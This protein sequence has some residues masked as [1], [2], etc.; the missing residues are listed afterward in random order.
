MT[1]S[2]A[3]FRARLGFPWC[4]AIFV[5]GSVLT[6]LP[7]FF[8]SHYY[9]ILGAG[10]EQADNP[11]IHWWHTVVT[12]FVHGGGFPG[13]TAHLAINCAFFLVLGSL[14]ERTLGT[15]RYGALC[16]A[17]LVVSFAL[18][19]ALSRYA[20]GISNVAWSFVAL[21]PV[22]IG[23]AW[24]KHRGRALRDPVFVAVVVLFVLGLIGLVNT[25]HAVAM[26]VGMPFVFAWRAVL[27]D[28]L[29]RVDTG[30]PLD[31]WGRWATGVAIAVPALLAGSSVSMSIA[32]VLGYLH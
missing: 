22:L 26:L 14:L 20:H 19:V 11:R 30:Q 9:L 7:M 4:T 17:C 13:L 24:R 23:H 29:H 16:G 32:A 1:L 27:R 28:N 2:N 31:R 5:A 18:K 21:A 15:A 3:L 12:T 8:S 6:S 25:W 10:N